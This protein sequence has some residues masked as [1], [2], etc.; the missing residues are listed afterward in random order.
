M[1][2]QVWPVQIVQKGLNRVR[3]FSL[4]H[5]FEGIFSLLENIKG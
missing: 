2:W 3:A 1:D 4:S 5:T